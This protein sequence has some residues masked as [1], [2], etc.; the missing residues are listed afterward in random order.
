[1]TRKE[2]EQIASLQAEIRSIEASM[3]SPK[4]TYVSVF[5]KDYRTGKGIPK[6]K[7]E[8]DDGESELKILRAELNRQRR[9]LLGKI[10]KAEDFIKSVDSSEMRTILRSYYINGQNQKEIGEELHYS[11]TAISTKLRMFWLTQGD[12]NTGRSRRH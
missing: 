3:R 9:K 4:S 12:S 11:Q 2:M 7:Q 8:L 6:S 1:M 5:Y 10:K